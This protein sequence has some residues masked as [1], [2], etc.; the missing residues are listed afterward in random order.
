MDKTT[1]LKDIATCINLVSPIPSNN[2]EQILSRLTKI[3]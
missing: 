3:Q 1:I 2:A